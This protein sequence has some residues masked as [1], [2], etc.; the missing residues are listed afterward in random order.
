MIDKELRRL[1]LPSRLVK[2]KLTL[3]SKGFRSQHKI[4]STCPIDRLDVFKPKAEWGDARMCTVELAT[5]GHMR[6]FRNSKLIV[7]SR[8]PDVIVDHI[9]TLNLLV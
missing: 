8:N 1:T 5:N 4:F 9:I 6:V 7:K 3:G 2:V